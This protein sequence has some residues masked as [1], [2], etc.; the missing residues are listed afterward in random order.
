MATSPEQVVLARIVGDLDAIDAEIDQQ[1]TRFEAFLKQKEADRARLLAF[2][3]YLEQQPPKAE[4]E[5]RTEEEAAQPSGEGGDQEGPAATTTGIMWAVTALQQLWHPADTKF[6][7]T[8]MQGIGFRPRAENPYTSL[9]STLRR[10]AQRPDSRIIKRE[11]LWGLRDWPE[12]VWAQAKQGRSRYV[13]EMDDFD[14]EDKNAL[15]S[16]G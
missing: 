10:S 5:L 3:E 11:G 1:R 6:L 2:K 7:L 12:D 13:I 14:L 16:A 8:K 9:F 15:E 4:E